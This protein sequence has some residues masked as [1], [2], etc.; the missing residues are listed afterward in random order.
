MPRAAK[1]PP[2]AAPSPGGVRSSDAGPSRLRRIA[3]APLAV[4]AW[5]LAGLAMLILLPICGVVVLVQGVAAA[6]AERLAV[7]VRRA[8]HR[9]A[10]P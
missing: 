10:R 5:A 2:H 4:A 8:T 3:L 7:R 6:V 9:Q 1:P